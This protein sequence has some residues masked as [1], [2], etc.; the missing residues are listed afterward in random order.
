M[1]ERLFSR[2]FTFL[3]LGQVTSLI[4]NFTLKFALAMYVLEQTGSATIFAALLAVA[5][6]PTI[7]LSPF[8]GMLADRM[9]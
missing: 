6:I 4:G 8:G 5:M 9:N 1:T 3:I 2:N 7:V